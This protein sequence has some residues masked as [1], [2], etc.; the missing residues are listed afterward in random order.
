MLRRDHGITWRLGPNVDGARILILDKPDGDWVPVY[1][2]EMDEMI[3]RMTVEYL[4]TRLNVR[5]PE[6]T[7]RG[8]NG[9]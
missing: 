5:L 2:S 8:G 9:R 7:R 3:D 1:T 4:E 6:S